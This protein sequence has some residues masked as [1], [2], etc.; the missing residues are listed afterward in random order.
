MIV[1]FTGN[2]QFRSPLLEEI[3]KYD[4][5]IEK[6][7]RSMVVGKLPSLYFFEEK[8]DKRRL[9]NDL[10]LN[11]HV[12]REK[13]NFLRNYSFPIDIDSFIYDTS[14]EI[15]SLNLNNIV[16][17]PNSCVFLHFTSE[18]LHEETLQSLKN[19]DQYDPLISSD[20]FW[21]VWD[22]IIRANN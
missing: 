10:L 9:Q 19:D 13:D 1:Q 15:L 3:E 20:I 21:E 12:L 4:I 8:I 18:I 14:G 7:K 11:Q 2:L 6:I 17:E 16:V 22:Q 5:V